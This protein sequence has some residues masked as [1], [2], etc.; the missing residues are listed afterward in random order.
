MIELT[1][2][3]WQSISSSPG[4][5]GKLVASLLCQAHD[6]DETVYPELYH[7]LCHQNTVGGVAYIA[8][9]HLAHIARNSSPQKRVWPLSIIGTVVASR[10]AFSETAAPFNADWLNDYSIALKE[11]LVLSTESL[12]HTELSPPEAQELIATVSAL[13]GLTDLAI[14]LFLQGGITELSRPICGEYLSYTKLPL[15]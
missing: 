7:Q 11:S 10:A 8:V 2:T 5:T 4:G 14:L 13:Q 3:L 15:N 1:S 9:P 12:Q 6:G